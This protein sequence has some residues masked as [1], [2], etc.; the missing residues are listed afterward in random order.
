MIFNNLSR[1]TGK[2]QEITLETHKHHKEVD[3]W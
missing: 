1:N 2:D 3:F